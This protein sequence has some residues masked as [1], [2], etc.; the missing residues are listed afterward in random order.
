MRS[1]DAI[2]WTSVPAAAGETVAFGGGKFIAAGNGIVLSTDRTTW[3]SVLTNTVTLENVRYGFGTF[4]AVGP[5]GALYISTNGT[6]WQNRSL[7][8]RQNLNAVNFA[9]DSFFVVGFGGT[10]YQSGYLT[11]TPATIVRLPQTQTVIAGT[12]AIVTAGFTGR[13]P[14]SFQWFKNGVP[15]PGGTDAALTIEQ[16]DAADTGSYHVVAVNEFGSQ[17]SSPATLNVAT[18]GVAVG[19]ESLYL[20]TGSTGSFR[21]IV[22]GGAPTGYEWRLNSSPIAGATNATLT[23]TNAQ[24][25]DTL[26]R[27]SVTAFFPFGQSAG[28]NS[29]SLQLVNSLDE[30]F[31]S[32]ANGPQSVPVGSTVEIAASL[33]G[34]TPLTYQWRKAGV[35]IPGATNAL[36]VFTNVQTSN[37]ADYSY[38]V[39]YIPGSLINLDASTLLVYSNAAPVLSG[40]RLLDANT[41]QLT[42]TGLVNRGYQIDYTT[43]LANPV[44]W[45]TYDVAY[46]TTNPLNYPVSLSFL[47][48]SPQYFFR[49]QILPP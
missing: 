31:L 36:L 23:F 42:F 35:I 49:V 29:G 9:N 41:L 25:A 22:T 10:I 43:N 8:T 32:Y 47:P 46:L 16:A 5:S 48:P 24:P 18:I 27:Y 4:M 28:T 6:N 14:M 1:T 37:S 11:D 39:T 33:A 12:T 21:A 13:L 34:P 30:I 17:T 38:S 44:V 7:R 26:G 40:G 20:F 15:L 3:T 2:T 45:N 19:P